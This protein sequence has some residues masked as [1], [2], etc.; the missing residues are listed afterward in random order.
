M[1][2][3]DPVIKLDARTL[4]HMRYF[5]EGCIIGRRVKIIPTFFKCEIIEKIKH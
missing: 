2:E 1:R 4:Y 5:I 3:L